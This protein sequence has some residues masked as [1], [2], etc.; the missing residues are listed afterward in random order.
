MTLRESL[1]GDV[2]RIYEQVN[3]LLDSEDGVMAE[4]K[5]A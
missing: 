2:Q 1:G 5:A 4:A 3:A